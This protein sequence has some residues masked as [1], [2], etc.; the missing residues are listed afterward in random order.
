[1]KVCSAILA[2]IVAL[3]SV[4]SPSKAEVVTVN[5]RPLFTQQNENIKEVRKVIFSKVARK[6][7]LANSDTKYAQEFAYFFYKLGFKSSPAAYLLFDDG[8]SVILN[9]DWQ[10]NQSE[11]NF[12][13][14]VLFVI[15]VYDKEF[16]LGKFQESLSS[17]KSTLTSTGVINSSGLT[18]SSDFAVHPFVVESG[19]DAPRIAFQA[20]DTTTNISSF[21]SDINFSNKQN[22]RLTVDSIVTPEIANQNEVVKG[23]ITIKNNS[24][25]TAFLNPSNYIQ[26]RFDT[27]SGF[28]VNNKWLTQRIALRTEDG[29]I[30]ANET[31]TFD[32]ELK[33]PILPGL[34]KEKLTVLYNNTVMNTKEIAMTVNKSDKKMLKIKDNSFGYIVVR[35]EPNA[36]S[37]DL[38]RATSGGIFFYTETRDNHYLIDFNGQSGWVPR[39]NVDLVQ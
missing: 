20:Q 29:F 30:K 7:V 6:Q 10:I 15:L 37:T 14:G 16:Q 32:F 25:F 19:E 17:F 11:N 31:K 36:T 22:P 24:N 35:K 27:N 18:S 26:I 23:S 4:I 9:P 2:I 21:F 12:D 5:T 8:T 33:A 38:G 13:Y 3:C 1:M 39:Q 34:K 28:F